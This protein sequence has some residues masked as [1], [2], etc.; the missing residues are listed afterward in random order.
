LTHQ[1]DPKPFYIEEHK[2]ELLPWLDKITYIKFQPEISGI[3]FSQKDLTFNPSSAA[4]QMERAQRNMLSKYAVHF[5]DDDIFIV[6]DLDE[7]AN[8]DVIHA[9]RN[10]QIKVDKARLE[11]QM[12]YYY[13][14]CKG[15]GVGEN[16]NWQQGFVANV[17]TIKNTPEGLSYLRVHQSMPVIQN[18]GWHFSYLGGAV[19]VSQKINAAAHTEINRPEINNLEYLKQCIELGVDYLGRA[20]YEFAFCPVDS[21]PVQLALLMRKNPRLLKVSML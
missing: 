20:G 1:G 5:N 9:I 3:D 7:L 17:A 6:T 10:G 11:M 8:P 16:K 4:W 18:A 12:H 15:V 19:R 2:D 13:L 21:Y 14:N